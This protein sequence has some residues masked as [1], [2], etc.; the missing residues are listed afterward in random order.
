MDAVGDSHV[1]ANEDPRGM[2]VPEIRLIPT[3]VH[4]RVL[5]RGPAHR[6]CAGLVVGFHGYMENAAIQ[7]ERLEAI[8]GA[9]AWTL[10]AVQGL[11]RFY[12]GRSDTVVA[13][14]MTR[15]DREAMIADN[16]AYVAR[17]VD[18]VPEADRGRVVYAGFSQGAAMAFRSG[19]RSRV[20]AAGILS[21]GGDVPPELVAE[22]T[23]FP[24][25]LLARGTADEWYTAGKLEADLAALAGR[26]A[27]VEPLVYPGGHEW[28]GDVSSAAG[29]FIASCFSS[30][31]A[32]RPPRSNA[33]R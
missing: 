7:M 1:T 15:E 16:L 10:L 5:V 6:P 30:G 14:W 31:A 24:R 33:T 28:T 9:D 19:T 2:P 25:I 4:G 11:H 23:S 29:A 18:A 22:A 27:T 26:R 17:A 3:T 21:V 12:R 32:P 8:P 13:S 20:P